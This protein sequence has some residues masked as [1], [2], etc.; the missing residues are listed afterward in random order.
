MRID[1]EAVVV[2]IN[3]PEGLKRVQVNVI[4]VF[5]GA[6]EATLP[7]ATYKLPIGVRENY[8]EFTPCQVN[9]VVW[10]DFPYFLPDGKPDTRRPR[11]TGG[12]HYAPRSIPNIPHESLG[13]ESKVIKYNG[14]T[15]EFLQNGILRITNEKQI[16]FDTPLLKLSGKVVSDGDQIASGISQVNHPHEDVVSGKGVSG[17][18]IK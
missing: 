4:G 6:D 12:V 15:I 8:G 2:N 13:N 18:P 5:D 3:D 16:I 9:D 7:W 10:V 17:K 14:T 1:H 11:I